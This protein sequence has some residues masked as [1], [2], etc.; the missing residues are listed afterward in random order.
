MFPLGKGQAVLLISIKDLVTQMWGSSQ[1]MQPTACAE[2]IWPP[3]CHF[4]EVDTLETGTNADTPAPVIA[5]SKN[6]PLFLV[7]EFCAFCQ[8]P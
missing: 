3:S 7:Q 6:C 4:V 8:H 1:V 2:I 5:V